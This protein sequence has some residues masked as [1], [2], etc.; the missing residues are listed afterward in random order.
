[1]SFNRLNYDTCQYKQVIAESTGSMRYVLGTPKNTCDPCFVD[2]PLIRMQKTGP[3][4]TG[5][6][7]ID[8]ELLNITRPNSRCPARK[9]VP[10][11]SS[12]Q[13]QQN[14]G[15]PPPKHCAFPTD[16]TRTSNPPCN[17]RGTGW[18]RWETLCKNPQDKVLVPFDFLIQNRLIVKDNHRPCIPRPIDVSMSLPRVM[19]PRACEKTGISCA[20][21]TGPASVHWQDPV[22][23]SKY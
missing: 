3:T 4:A 12:Q 19:P 15:T 13:Q 5:L 21:I 20:S 6:I 2:N 11:C 16:E 8:S 14:P 22:A 18:N 17:L 9:Y 23:I 1:M 10:L 7:D